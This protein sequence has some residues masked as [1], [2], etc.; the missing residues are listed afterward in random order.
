M[1]KLGLSVPVRAFGEGCNWN[2]EP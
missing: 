1:Q 2:W